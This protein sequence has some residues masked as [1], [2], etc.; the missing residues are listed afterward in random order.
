M[1]TTKKK[2]KKS[3]KKSCMLIQWTRP[4]TPTDSEGKPVCPDCGEPA[5]MILGVFGNPCWAHK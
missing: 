4:I 5:E 3:K 2:R 1:K